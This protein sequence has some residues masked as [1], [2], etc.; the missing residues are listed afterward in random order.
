M[1]V[2][3]V[4]GHSALEPSLGDGW[5]WCGP[6]TGAYRNSLGRPARVPGLCPCPCCQGEGVT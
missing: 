6:G 5:S 1:Q 3:G 2:G 4:P